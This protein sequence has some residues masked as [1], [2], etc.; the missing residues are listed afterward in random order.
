[1][2]RPDA[3]DYLSAEF[4]TLASAAGICAADDALGYGTALDMALAALGLS[5]EA[6]ISAAQLSNYYALL[7][8]Y[9]LVRL[10]RHFAFHSD[11]SIDGITLHDSQVYER[12]K[13]MLARAEGRVSDLGLIAVPGGFQLGRINLDILE[14]QE[15]W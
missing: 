1:M 4:G 5:S 3:I 7:D 10:E 2:T 12:I 11:I 6:E 15:S 13:A 14:P 9:G 8:Y